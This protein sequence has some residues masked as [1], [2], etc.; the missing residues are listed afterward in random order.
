MKIVV[1]ILIIVLILV[2]MFFKPGYAYVPPTGKD[3]IGVDLRT[4]C[5]KQADKFGSES[6]KI[7]IGKKVPYTNISGC[8]ESDSA[9]Q[10]W[11]QKC[12]QYTDNEVKSAYAKDSG[13]DLVCLIKECKIRSAQYKPDDS[14]TSCVKETTRGSGRHNKPLY[15]AEDFAPD[16][17]TDCEIQYDKIYNSLNNITIG[18]YVS[19]TSVSNC[20][21]LNN[22]ISDWK[23][24]C[25]NY[26]D[27]EVAKAFVEDKNN[28]L[29]CL[30]KQC[31]AR[32]SHTYKT[33]DSKTECIQEALPTSYG[34]DYV[35]ESELG[36]VDIDLDDYTPS[37][38]STVNNI[39]KHAKNIV[40]GETFYVP[41]ENANDKKVRKA[42]DKWESKCTKYTDPDQIIT[43]THIYNSSTSTD[44]AYFC[45]VEECFFGYKPDAKRKKCEI[46]NEEL[47]TNVTPRPAG[48]IPNNN[49]PTILDYRAS[50]GST[51]SY[52]KKKGKTEQ[53]EKW[54]AACENMEKPAAVKSIEV[55]EY[56]NK[57]EITL[58]CEITECIDHF[59]LSES[60][61][62][63]E[64]EKVDVISLPNRNPLDNNQT[65]KLPGREMEVKASQILVTA[66]DSINGILGSQITF[67]DEEQQNDK[68]A[69]AISQWE[70]K[71]N[72]Y[73][74]DSDDLTI[75]VTYVKKTTSGKKKARSNVWKCLIKRCNDDEAGF[76]QKPSA[77]ELSCISI[78]GE[79]C[80]PGSRHYTKAYYDAK[81]QNCI[82]TACKDNYTLQDNKCV[83]NKS[84]ARSAERQ[85]KKHTKALQKDIANLTKVFNKVIEKFVK[86]CEKSGGTII[87]WECQSGSNNDQST[88]PTNTKNT[89]KTPVA[90][91][92]AKTPGG[93]R[94]ARR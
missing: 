47:Y 19:Y 83:S 13:R 68:V 48:E 54:I 20:S 76:T 22:V 65:D 14:G 46:N 69:D 75:D 39:D 37:V 15:D 2:P 10:Y 34:R 28:T 67:T 53:I 35:A 7:V 59:V 45:G 80:K 32:N 56:K 44:I 8:S 82:I 74:E 17:K 27:V 51:V 72:N 89:K 12:E 90:N 41:K 81:T 1:N 86:E 79:S 36:T 63:C 84:I 92:K 30:I 23:R 55:K 77:D 88:A 49:E 26:T 16:I 29:R 25:E 42:L 50:I 52:N 71:C 40:I 33:N 11:K 78:N 4:D 6:D 38:E 61:L 43:K 64:R 31:K 58:K 93:K 91:K 9:I 5:E 3:Y 73:P 70:K 18:S 94:G 85:K 57:K 66:N 60:K 24:K 21:S 87:D 62:Y